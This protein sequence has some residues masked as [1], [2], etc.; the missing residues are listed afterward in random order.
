M[1]RSYTIL[2][3]HGIAVRVHPSFGILLLWVIFHWGVQ[4]GGGLSHLMFGLVLL[5]AV[6]TFVVVHELGHSLMALQYGVRVHDITLLPIGGVARLDHVPDGARREAMISL[7]GPAANVALMAMLLPWLFVYGAANSYSSIGQY[8]DLLDDVSI[9][10]LLMSFVFV[11]FALVVF[12][13]APVFPLDGGRIFRAVLSAFVGRDRATRT[14]VAVGQALAVL[15]AIV[16][17]LAHDFMLPLMALFAIFAAYGEGKAVRLEASLRRLR[18]GQFAL[19]DQGG[20]A[21]DRPLRFA[22]TGG[23]RDMAVTDGGQVIGMLWRRQVLSDSS[24]GGSDLTIGEVMDTNFIPVEVHDSV[25]DVQRLMRETGR[26]AVPVV[27]DG[28]Y[29]GIFTTDRFIHVYRYVNGQSRSTQLI[30]LAFSRL[31][32]FRASLTRQSRE[33]WRRGRA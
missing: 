8:I 20:V 15:I 19:W 7:A 3:L 27:E 14:A 29:R 6:F 13:L 33:W 17:I 26:W 32:E 31:A 28:F 23:P 25:F 10:G 11:N 9:G 24:G 4:S 21:P 1:F 30:D 16:G 18:V 22:M 2:T 12:N 5:V